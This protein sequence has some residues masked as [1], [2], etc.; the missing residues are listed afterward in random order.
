MRLIAN[1]IDVA[2]TSM[3]I[4]NLVFVCDSDEMIQSYF[5]RHDCTQSGLNNVTVF[6]STITIL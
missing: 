5:L 4:M 3:V 6:M 1:V 2:T